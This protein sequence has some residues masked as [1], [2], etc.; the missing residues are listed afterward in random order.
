MNPSLIGI[1][2]G[3]LIIILAT[4]VIPYIEKRKERNP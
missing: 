4:R 3:I 2:T 1:L